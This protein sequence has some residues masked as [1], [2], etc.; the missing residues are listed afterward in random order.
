MTFDSVLKW[1]LSAKPGE[2][3]IYHRGEQLSN[4]QNKL[5]FSD[6]VWGARYCYNGGIVD[7]KQYRDGS[8]FFYVAQKKRTIAKPP[9]AWD[10][11]G[12]RI[13]GFSIPYRFFRNSSHAHEI[14]GKWGARDHG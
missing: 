1:A 14:D 12:N 3:Y 2:E 13:E 9:P 7:F 10:M 11:D 5:D 8:Q 6:A 4:F